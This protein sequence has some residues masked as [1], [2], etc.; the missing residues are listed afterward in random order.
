[1]LTDNSF[2][3]DDDDTRR[4]RLVLFSAN[5]GAVAVELGLLPAKVTEAEGAQVE[6]DDA[7]SA[8]TRET[9]ESQTVKSDPAP[10]T[11]PDGQK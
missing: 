11:K 5:I 3:R 10:A 7:V 6:W 2:T 9:G 4:E 8:A 1:M